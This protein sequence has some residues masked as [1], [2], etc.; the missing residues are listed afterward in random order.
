MGN[1]WT[2]NMLKKKPIKD[3][4]KKPGKVKFKKSPTRPAR[5]RK[6]KLKDWEVKKKPGPAKIEVDPERVRELARF[7]YTDEE[8]A[9]VMGINY[10]TFK[11]RKRENPE[12]GV[13]L[14][15]GKAN[16]RRALRSKQMEIAIK[17]NVSMLQFL[18]KQ[19]LDQKEKTESEVKGTVIMQFTPDMT[20]PENA[21][22]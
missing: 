6:R 5:A 13:A 7:M 16:A 1:T 21:D 3:L 18:G 14:Q 19:Y 8:I 9:V 12:I 10:D 22:S 20:K 15:E 11:T 2:A 4:K 17:G